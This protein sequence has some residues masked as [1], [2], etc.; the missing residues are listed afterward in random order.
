MVRNQYQAKMMRICGHEDM[1]SFSFNNKRE[2]MA[3]RAYARNTLC[4]ECSGK[5]RGLIVAGAPGGFHRVSPVMMRGTPKRVT[6][7]TQIRLEK[8]RK[9]GPVMAHLASLSED[10][11]ARK[12]LAVYEMLFAVTAAV[13]WIDNRS[14][15]AFCQYWLVSEIEH[16][17]R[18]T[19]LYSAH[20]L[21]SSVYGHCRKFE[22]AL[23]AGARAVF[24]ELEKVSAEADQSAQV[25]MG[26]AAA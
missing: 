2:R 3:D 22:P 21:P 14:P 26:E 5:V 11:L 9:F 10:P 16:L 20:Y 8:L 18:S 7:A 15:N 13:F 23:I 6:W 19:D 17:S 12:A 1:A 24:V 4:A 25:Q